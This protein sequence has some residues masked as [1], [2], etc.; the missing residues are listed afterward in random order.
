MIRT[1]CI[2]MFLLAGCSAIQQTPEPIQRPELVRSAPLPPIVQNSPGGE[3]KL[4]VAILVLK[5]GAVGDAD[6]ISSSGDPDWDSLALRSIMQWQ[7]TPGRREGRPMEVWL[8]QPLR[9][10]FHE[11]VVMNLA[12]LISATEQA[13]DSL[14]LL[15]ERG[16]DFDSLF[17][18]A[19]ADS[20]VR[21][22]SLGSVDVSMYAKQLRSEFLRL[23]EG[24]VTRPLRIGAT[25]VIYKRIKA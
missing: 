5:D 2:L 24:D 21:R 14:Y 18:L 11:P 25:F 8:R 20:G 10:Q 4:T 3:M 13:A 16:A 15:I 12:G 19:R 9:V 1:L 22:T 6:L 23:N 7:Y 17:A